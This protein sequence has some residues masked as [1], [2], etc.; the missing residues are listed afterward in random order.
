VQQKIVRSAW[1]KRLAGESA[2]PA[3]ELWLRILCRPPTAAERAR[4]AA[5]L[6]GGERRAALDD[7]AWALINTTEF[8]TAH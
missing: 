6:A 3:D 1:L 4:C 5:A 8:S 2:D 7:L